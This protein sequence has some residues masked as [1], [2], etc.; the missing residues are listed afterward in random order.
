MSD[1]VVVEIENVKVDIVNMK[2]AYKHKGVVRMIPKVKKPWNL[3]C[4]IINIFLPG[5]GTLIAAAKAKNE[6]CLKFNVIVGILQFMLA[7]ILIGWIWSIIWGFIIWK[8]GNGLSSQFMRLAFP[9]T[10]YKL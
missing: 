2:V 1:P 8:R 7:M 5:I 6:K 9:E 10:I 3:Y 4:F